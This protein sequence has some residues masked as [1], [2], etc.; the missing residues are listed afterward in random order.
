MRN[1]CWRKPSCRTAEINTRMMSRLAGAA[2]TSSRPRS[3]L[4]ESH[5]QIALRDGRVG[6]QRR[7]RTRPHHLPLLDDCVPVGELHERGEML[8][9][10]QN[11][12]ALRFQAR[13]AFPDFEPQ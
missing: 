8:V 9:D 7:R 5:L 1:A 13:K 11:G 2:R 3:F 6:F 10:E 4:L 12:L